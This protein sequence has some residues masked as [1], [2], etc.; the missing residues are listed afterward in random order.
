M[1]IYTASDQSYADSVINHIDP[2]KEFFKYRLYR[3][4]CVK[5][6]T[7][8]GTL[9]VKDLRI[10]KNVRL[11]NMIIIDNSVLSFAFH[12]DNGIPILPYYSNKEDIELNFLKGY[13][14]KLA[15]YDNLTVHNGST[16]K[17]RNLL[18]ETKTTMKEEEEEEDE[19][20]NQ[21][22][23][24]VVNKGDAKKK[25]GV[26]EVKKTG[27]SRTNQK[28]NLE[29]ETVKINNTNKPQT[30]PARKKSKMQTK[31]YDMLEKAK[32]A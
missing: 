6:I 32:K 18:E 15:Q 22:A 16:F 5:L 29:K 21:N 12:L 14:T 20:E 28:Q 17:L 13:L 8:N 26:S 31:I 25:A 3:H 10:I 19:I 11:E 4:N 2:M 23:K 30:A 7:E 1:I 24:P 9:Y 27:L